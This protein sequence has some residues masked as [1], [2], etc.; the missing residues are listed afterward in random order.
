MTGRRSR[1]PLGQGLLPLAGLAV[2]AA[3]G[4]LPGPRGLAAPD[5]EPPA[6]WPT[7]TPADRARSA[8]NLKQIALAFHNHNDT[9]NGMPAHAIYSKA[10]KPLLSWRV[11][12]L[13]FVEGGALYREF[14]LDEAWDS[15]HNKKLLARMPRVYAPTISGKP[16][17]P[18]TTYY[19]V[20]TGPDTPFNPRAVRAAGPVTLG[21]RI[22]AS[23]PDGTSNTLLVVEAGE[24]V[25]WTKPDDLV[26]DPKKPV[27]KLGGLFPEG[28]HAA[29]VDGSTRFLGRKIDD[30]A[31]RALIT[32]AGGEIIDWRKVPLARP[33]AAGR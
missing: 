12:V 11:A 32:P 27:P 4:A 22:P 19:Q 2:A 25:P 21:G 17:K 7:T 16:A 3:L 15:P 5:P 33:P 14:R 8:N 18:N 1:T 26:Y 24:A 9:Y 20:F 31:L 13:P 23:F 6:P 10:G 29:L 30:K 28:F